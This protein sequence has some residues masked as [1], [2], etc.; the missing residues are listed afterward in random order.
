MIIAIIYSFSFNEMIVQVLNE[1]VH[2]LVQSLNVFF[3]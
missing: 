1:S 2:T 3:A